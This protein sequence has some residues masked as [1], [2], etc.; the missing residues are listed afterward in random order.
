MLPLYESNASLSGGRKMEAERG[1]LWCL[2]L[3]LQ[4][5]AEFDP[6][7]PLREHFLEVFRQTG[8][9]LWV[10]ARLGSS[11][12]Q[13]VWI[14]AKSRARFRQA[15]QM[16]IAKLQ[17]LQTMFDTFC[18]QRNGRTRSIWRFDEMSKAAESVLEEL[19]TVPEE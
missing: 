9:K 12:K 18:Q 15:V 2:L 6:A 14:Q 1:P 17:E 7:T 8:A 19:E 4:P 11:S 3:L 10:R 5:Y 13:A 16:T